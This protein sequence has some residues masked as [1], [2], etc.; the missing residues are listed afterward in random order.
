MDR[1]EQFAHAQGCNALQLHQ[2]QLMVEEW[3]QNLLSH[4]LRPDQVLHVQL[5]LED[6]GGAWRLTL[7]DNG[8][9][10][11]P[12]AGPA[13]RLDRELDELVPGGWGLH[14]IRS[15][16]SDS[17]YERSDGMNCLSLEFKK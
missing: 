10:F 14:L 6:Q 16:P 13:P 8:P 11:D 9:A 7:N 15:I 4:A 5:Q 2:M 17:H 1:I 3:M 12:L